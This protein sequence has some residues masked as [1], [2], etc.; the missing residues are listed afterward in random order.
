MATIAEQLASYVVKL[1]YEDLPAG[2]VSKARA[3]ILDH[4]GVA[5]RGATLPQVKPALKLVRELGGKPDSTLTY[6]GDKVAMPYAAYCNAIFGHSCEFDDALVGAGHPGVCT[7]PVAMA[8]AEKLGRSGK[9]VITAIVA[10]Y[11]VTV[12]TGLPMHHALLR[13]GWHPMKVHGIFGAAAT[14]AKLLGLNELE[15]AN[16][17]AIAGSDSSGTM[18]Y[19]QSGGEVKRFHAGMLARSGSQAALLA[20]AGL[21]G[22]LTIF[23]GKRGIFTLFGEGCAADLSH[24][25]REF[26][27][28]K[29]VFKMYPAVG[30]HHSALDAVRQ[31][32]GE[33]KFSHQDI[34]AINVGVIDW[35]VLHGCAIY[36]PTDALSAQMSLPYSIGLRV[37]KGSND[38]SFYLDPQLWNDKT[39]LSVADKVKTSAMPIDD[40]EAQLGAR[41]EIKLAD[42]RKLE[43]YQ[44]FFRGHP[45]NPPTQAELEA[46]FMELVSAVAPASQADRLRKEIGGLEQ[47]TDLSTVRSLL[48]R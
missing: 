26:S 15:T 23:E 48:V 11:E 21:T 39:V 8:L 12:Q 43:A 35:A 33:H 13:K 31:V 1:R 24:L 18:E 34:R 37:V 4:L 22:P 27:I 30:T 20:G 44:P 25:G 5:M 38:I 2:V 40:D 9:D 6:H 46:K 10:G 19:D 45:R 41:V 29:T 3:C 28:L 7:I 36:R 17:L 32:M 42:G 14:A 16:A 47:L